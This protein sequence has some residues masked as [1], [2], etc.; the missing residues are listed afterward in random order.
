MSGFCTFKKCPG[1]G[2]ADVMVYSDDRTHWPPAPLCHDCE[3]KAAT[4]GGPLAWV[5]TERCDE[6]TV[7]HGVFTTEAKAQRAK[8]DKEAATDITDGF[9]VSAYPLDM[10]KVVA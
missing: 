6:S 4:K 7:I 9:D 3:A 2:E 8:R 10:M 5:L 1:C